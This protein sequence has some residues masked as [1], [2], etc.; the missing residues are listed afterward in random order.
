VI[1]GSAEL[2]SGAISIELG[3]YLVTVIDR[4]HYLVEE[5]RE[6]EEIQIRHEDGKH[7]V[8]DIICNYGTSRDTTTTI[9]EELEWNPEVWIK[10]TFRN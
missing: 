3:A 6:R 9:V 1:G 10:V 2:F 7:E 5:K 8:Y 4:D